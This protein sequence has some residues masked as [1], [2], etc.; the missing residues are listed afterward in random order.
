MSQIKPPIVGPNLSVWARQVSAYLQRVRTALQFK[1]TGESAAENGILLWDDTLLAPVVSKSG[2]FLPIAIGVIPEKIVVVRTAIELSGT[3]LS[4]VV[5]LVDGFIDMGSTQITVPQGGLTIHGHDTGVSR[6]TTSVTS[7]TLFIDD[8]VFAGNLNLRFISI[9]VT[10]TGSQIF[11]LDNAGNGGIFIISEANFTGCKSAGEV[12]AYTQGLFDEFAMVAC[13]DGL[14]MSGTWAA[15]FAIFTTVIDPSGTPFTGTFLK[16]G[17]ALV[18]NGSIVSNMNATFI[19][20]TGAVCDFAPSNITNDVG[21][22]MTGVRVNPASN[23]FPN[24]PASSVKARFAACAG[25]DNTYVGGQWAITTSTAT[26][27][28][29]VSAGVYLKLAGTTTYSD[30]QWFSGAVNNAMTYDGAQSI[31][32]KAEFDMGLT[33][34]NNDVVKFKIRHFDSS[35]SAFIDIFT[36]GGDTMNA[37]SRVE[38]GGGHGFAKMDT[39]DR[40][41]LWI[42]SSGA[43]NTTGSLDGILSVTERPS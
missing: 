33:G 8:G 28:S 31:S 10:G 2:A 17:T 22:L 37:G 24:M 5:Y 20:A 32:V 3:L 23:A 42:N 14:T 16:A 19:D 7:Q 18:I 38:G 13:L 12:T 39:N 29:S 21:F 40:I 4:D 41:E 1:T 6:L 34:T 15:G 43:K 30:L 35:A 26:N 25:T 36:S 9:R 27:L 11:D